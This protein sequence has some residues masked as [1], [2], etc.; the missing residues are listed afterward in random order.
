MKLKQ[1]ILPVLLIN[2]ISC[3]QGTLDGELLKPKTNDDG[4]LNNNIFVD[5]MT[6]MNEEEDLMQGSITLRVK[7]KYG[8]TLNLDKKNMLFN[9][10][11][12]KKFGSK[13]E[14]KRDITSIFN[15]LGQKQASG[16]ILIPTNETFYYGHLRPTQDNTYAYS[17]EDQLGETY[18]ETFQFPSFSYKYLQ[19]IQND[20]VSIYHTETEFNEFWIDYTIASNTRDTNIGILKP[21]YS[22]E[23]TIVFDLKALKESNF[24]DKII[25]KFKAKKVVS[26][27]KNKQNNG[28]E[29]QM[30]YNAKEV[31]LQC[32]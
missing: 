1:I 23:D 29:H 11:N 8:P 24:C 10:Q 3:G 28:G 2:L 20:E 13:A 5:Y 6:V 9:E 27:P 32:H 31:Q 18:L 16:E 7:E 4:S 12:L 15:S 19:N 25:L 30:I 17:Y 14:D 26:L 21:I 22:N